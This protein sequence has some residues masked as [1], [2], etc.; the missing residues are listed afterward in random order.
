MHQKAMLVEDAIAA[1]G[2]AN[3]DNRSFRLNFELTA[4]VADYGFND[5]VEEMFLEDFR[6]YRLM[7]PRAL[8]EKSFW[9]RLLV[10]LARLTALML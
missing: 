6:N 2:K 10:R 1:I 4:L 5:K 9:F 3:F 8:A 7:Q